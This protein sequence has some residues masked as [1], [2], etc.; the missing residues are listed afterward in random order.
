MEWWALLIVATLLITL[1]LVGGVWIPVT[2]GVTGMALLALDGRL[3]MFNSIGILF[4]NQAS[5]FVL[6]GIPLFIFM[7]ELILNSGISKQ[8]YRSVT[9]WVSFIPGKL[10]NTNIMASTIFSAV[11]GSSVATAASISAVAIPELRQRGYKDWLIYGSLAAGG[12]LGILIPPSTAMIIYGSIV[13]ESVAKL[14]IAGILP[15]LLLSSLFIAFIGILCW[16]KPHLAPSE[17]GRATLREFFASLPGFLPMTL[18]II[19]VIGTIYS[20]IVTPTEAAAMGVL[21]AIVI[22]RAFGTLGPRGILDAGRKAVVATGMLMFII[23]GTEILSFAFARMGLTRDLVNWVESLNADPWTVFFVVCL[24]YLLLGTFIE[25][26]SMLLLSLPLVHP[27]MMSL[28]FDSIWFGVVLVILMEI[29]L[30]SPPVGMNLF[31][32]QSY[33]K[34]STASR[35]VQLGAI[36]FVAMMLVAILALCLWPELALWLPGHL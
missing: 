6:L 27:L 25:A 8:F 11:S 4:W 20:G 9:P 2:L 15:G 36:P 1:F 21:G 22:G 29:A 5:S 23:L 24:L 19:T 16:L 35:D 28:G 3:N 18:L 12:T 14:F 31:V 33:A 34:S 13:N 32:I 26:L 30:I 17:G 7:G 10:Y